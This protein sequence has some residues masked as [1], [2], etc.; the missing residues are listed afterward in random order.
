MDRETFQKA[1]Y[2]GKLV[3]HEQEF[4][5]TQKKGLGEREAWKLADIRKC[6]DPYGT[7]SLGDKNDRQLEPLKQ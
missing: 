2:T 5:G 4:Q 3:Y 1:D 6:M 7:D